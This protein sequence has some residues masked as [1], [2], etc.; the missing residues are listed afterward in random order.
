M[1]SC[2]VFKPFN[3]FEIILVHGVKKGSNFISQHPWLKRLSLLLVYSCPL[4]SINWTQECRQVCFWALSV[5]LIYCLFL[6]QYFKMFWLLQLWRIVWDLEMLGSQLD[7]FS[8][9]CF[10]SSVTYINFRIICSS[11]WG[12]S[13]NCDRNCMKSVDC[14]G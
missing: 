13:G 8:Q 4:G 11:S 14:S 6:C 2:P 1:V 3:Y 7:I 12:M 10:G 5:P 9:N